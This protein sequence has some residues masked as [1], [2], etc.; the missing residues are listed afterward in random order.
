MNCVIACGG[1]AGHI[2]PGIAIAH[3]IRKAYPQM[4]VTFIGT[5][6]SMEERLV[7]EAGYP[8]RTVPMQGLKRKLTLSNIKTGYLMIKAKRQIK[9][10]LASLMPRFV[11]GTGGYVCYPTLKAAISLG[12]PTCVHESNAVLGLA[13]KL[14]APNVDRIWLGFS[15]AVREIKQKEKAALVGNPL[16]PAFLVSQSKG[17]ARNALGI[18]HSD[19]VVLSFGGS[20][21]SEA[22]NRTMAD[23]MTGD[24]PKPIKL[25]HIC[26]E[27]HYEQYRDAAKGTSHTLLA[28]TDQMPQLM[29]AADLVIARCGAMT[30]TELAHTGAAAILVPS[31]YVAA[32]HQYKNA[33][34]L[35]QAGAAEMIEEE[36]FEP[37]RVKQAIVRLYASPSARSRM[38]QMMIAQAQTD[39]EGRILREIERLLCE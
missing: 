29:R 2:N 14:L 1:T 3:L 19:F 21:G 5:P 13:V 34:A 38:K 27:S 7:K 28:Y 17:A 25:I 6:D 33:Q 9:G 24:L 10:I 11:I 4:S 35:C 8:I 30:L 12:I 26:G 22:I 37:Q 32:N 20:R 15:T 39:T 36:Q 16:R 31:P 23:L 18:P